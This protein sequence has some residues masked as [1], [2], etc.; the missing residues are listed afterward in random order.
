[1]RLVAAK[2]DHGGIEEVLHGRAELVFTL[3]KGRNGEKSEECD[4]NEGSGFPVHILSCDGDVE[5]DIE[6]GQG[7][8]C[9]VGKRVRRREKGVNGM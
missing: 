8:K 2:I 9:P 3:R 5:S 1:M 6:P 7:G 4:R